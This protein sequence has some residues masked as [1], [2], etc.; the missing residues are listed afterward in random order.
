MTLDDIRH[1][2]GLAL[3][4]VQQALGELKQ[5]QRELAAKVSRQGECLARLDT[6]L[7]ERTARRHGGRLNGHAKTMGGA[8]MMAVVWALVEIIQT[9]I[10]A[11]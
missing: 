10:A 1:V 2:V 9:L 4:P 3:V 6:R 7:D 8:G 11:P 5:A